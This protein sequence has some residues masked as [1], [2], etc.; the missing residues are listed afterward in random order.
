MIRR[1]NHAVLYVR[2]PESSAA[3]YRDV[4]GFEVVASMGESDALFLVAANS[5]NGHDLGLFRAGTHAVSGDSG[6]ATVGLYHLAWE[7]DTLTDLQNMRDRL[8]EAGA[9][10]GESDHGESKSLYG[11]DPDGIEFEVM[12]E[13]PKPLLDPE[14][15]AITT[16]PLDWDA[17]LK[18]FGGATT[19]NV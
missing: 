19:R 7:V 3:F 4:L 2:D 1:L 12:W 14:A 8:E 13:V 9:L 10:V 16:R 18:R 11:H 5:D 6:T 17:T 15:D